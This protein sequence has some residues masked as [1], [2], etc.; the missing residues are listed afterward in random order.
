[1]IRLRPKIYPAVNIRKRFRCAGFSGERN[2]SD[3]EPNATSVGIEGERLGEYI[4]WFTPNRERPR[5]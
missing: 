5:R 3:F 4:G 2:H 1:M